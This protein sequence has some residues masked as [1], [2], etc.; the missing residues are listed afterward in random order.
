MGRMFTIALFVALAIVTLW[1]QLSEKRARELNRELVAERARVGAMVDSLAAARRALST[2]PV[3]RVS[4]GHDEA[5]IAR[6][7]K[8]GLADPVRDIRA[9][10]E[11]HPELIPFPGVLGG[12]MF[13][14]TDGLILDGT[15]K[16]RASFEDGHVG[17]HGVFEYRVKN[18]RI[19]WKRLW[20]G[21]N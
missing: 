9:S 20:A 13:F 18:G 6:L 5:E 8:A 4:N 16:V 14:L 21:M 17:G 15:G 3:N 10:L 2:I 1:W 12:T 19:T 11:S 7:R